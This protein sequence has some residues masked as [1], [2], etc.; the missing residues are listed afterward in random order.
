[1]DLRLVMA[2]G[3][4]ARPCVKNISDG[5]L[6]MFLCDNNIPCEV[7]GLN[8]NL[9]FQKQK[10]LK[11]I[12]CIANAQNAKPTDVNTESKEYHVVSFA[13]ATMFLK[14][15]NKFVKIHLLY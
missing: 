6:K 15:M 8:L 5:F 4:Q 2:L 1:M 3:F 14:K 13:I 7:N 12:Q 11:T 10:L 9:K